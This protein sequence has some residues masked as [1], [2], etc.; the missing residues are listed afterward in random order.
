MENRDDHGD[1]AV[2]V[3]GLFDAPRRRYLLYCLHLF[4][5]P[6]RLSNIAYQ[7]SIWE[8]EGTADDLVTA[9]Y[10][11]YMSLYH[12]HLPELTAAGIVEYDQTEDMVELGARDPDLKDRLEEHLSRELDDLLRAEHA[13]VGADTESALPDDLYRALAAPERRQLLS[14][15]LDRR[16][17][18][19]EEATTVLVGWQTTTEGPVGPDERDRLREALYHVHLPLLEDVGLLT[20]DREDDVVQLSTL[21]GPVRDAIRFATR[22]DRLTPPDRSR[23][24]G[25]PRRERD[26]T[27]EGR[28]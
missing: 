2:D 7:V 22:Q 10:R 5:N 15:L 1:L 9:R 21:S 23:D 13:T 12:D 14:A 25:S 11:T 17:L 28:T 16:E 3:S 19:F 27:D 18:T 20:Y 8:G 4:T 6:V 26:T 24:D